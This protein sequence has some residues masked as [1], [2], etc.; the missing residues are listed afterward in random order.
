[1]DRLERNQRLTGAI[2][3]EMGGESTSNVR[4]GRRGGQVFSATVDFYVAEHQNILAAS[5]EEEDKA[6]IA[7]AK[8]YWPDTPK[9]FYIP[10]A[11][12]QVSYTP[13]VTFETDAHSVSYAYA[14]SDAN[15]LVVGGGQRVAQGTLSKRSFMGIDPYV[16][17]VDSEHDSIMSEALEEAL[18]QSILQQATQPDGPWQP[19][20]LGRL[21]ELV[22]TQ[23]KE[24]WEA[25]KI[26][27][28]EA[29]DLQAASV[30]PGAAEMGAAGQPG[31]AMAGAPGTAGAAIPP[32]NASQV[33]LS[34]M[35]MNLRNPQRRINEGS[36]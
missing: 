30:G 4:T 22:Y 15:T 16:K 28:K 26:V 36:S 10:L 8:A 1:M 34:T 9:T 35:L 2:P 29:Q 14:G 23:D 13:S 24:I 32:A 11:K 19:D 5:L 21:I 17:D 7:I 6:A 31:M 25:V 3:A 20:Q 27:H 33:N 18:M 12:G